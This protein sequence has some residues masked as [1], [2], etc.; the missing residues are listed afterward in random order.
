MAKKEYPPGSYGAYLADLIKQHGF[1]QAEFAKQLN[2]SRTY[3]FDL[4]N[5]RVKPPAPDMQKR[6]ATVLKLKDS[7]KVEFFD[8][9]ALGRNEIP[10]DIFDYLF[11]NRDALS[12]IRERMRGHENG[13]KRS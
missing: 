12:E 11:N 3:L 1:S 4:F 6:I 7:E 5:G 8:T 13:K 2:I 10:K 9:T